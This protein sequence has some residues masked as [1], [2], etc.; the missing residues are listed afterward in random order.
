MRRYAG[1]SYGVNDISDWVDAIKMNEGKR[2][3][4]PESLIK[5]V[6]GE[7][8]GMPVPEPEAVPVPDAEKATEPIVEPEAP[9]EAPGA[10][11]EDP[12]VVEEREEPV[13]REKEHVIDEL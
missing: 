7:S 5:D 8:E 10:T 1:S 11:L 3:K 4:L 6:S 2:D 13:R 9:V 12:V